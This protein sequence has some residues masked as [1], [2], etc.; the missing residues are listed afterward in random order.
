MKRLF[1]A[2]K[3]TTLQRNEFKM[4]GQYAK[5]SMR[6][7]NDRNAQ[8]GPGMSPNSA[9]SAVKK[10]AHYTEAISKHTHELAVESKSALRPCVP[11]LRL[12]VDRP[13]FV[14]FPKLFVLRRQ[15]A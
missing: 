15:R 5:F 11:R 8:S 10:S 7:H 3:K 13:L 6:A 12:R 9:V 2:H 4:D 1:A 14:L